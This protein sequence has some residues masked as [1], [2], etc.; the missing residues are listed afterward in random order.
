MNNFENLAPG[1]KFNVIII[2][3][4]GPA[5]GRRSGL[6][7][8]LDSLLGREPDS[9]GLHLEAIKTGTG[10]ALNSLGFRNEQFEI[11]APPLTGAG[12][13][14]ETVFNKIDEAD[15]AIADISNR[16]ANVFYEIALLNALGTPIILLDYAKRPAPFYWT[17]DYI[18]GLSD[19]SEAAIEAKVTPIF[20]SYFNSEEVTLL[21]NNLISRFYGAPLVDVASA[22]SVAVGFFQNFA[23]HVLRKRDGVLTI[24]E[25]EL[26]DL[27]VVRPERLNDQDSDEKTLAAALSGARKDT[28][29]APSHPRG[30]VFADKIVNRSIVDFPTP[31]YALYNSPRY[32]RLRER[33]QFAD[34][35][36]P[37]ARE[38]AYKKMEAKIIA[39][40]FRTLQ[41]LIESDGDLAQ[42]RY[43]VVPISGF[44]LQ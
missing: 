16:S 32:R 41:G 29:K 13:I 1:G 26:D 38:R 39:S 12:G 31:L 2:G 14:V 37:E 18:V 9:I 4:M 40:Y 8:A 23:K 25:S 27:V 30:S 10:R 35:F 7:K 20:K 21:S 5:K 19:Y 24:Y 11:Y 34:Y 6:G 17:M 36:S 28:L 22:T 33:L 3:P 43:R 15:F 42:R 44:K